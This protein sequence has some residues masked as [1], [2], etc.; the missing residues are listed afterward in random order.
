MKNLSW[1]DS[2]GLPGLEINNP[3]SAPGIAYSSQSTSR[4]TGSRKSILITAGCGFNQPLLPKEKKF[5][6]MIEVSEGKT[7][8]KIPLV[9]ELWETAVANLGI[10]VYLYQFIISPKC[11]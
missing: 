11:A 4:S 1:R 7:Y 8:G 9:N 10:S 2:T 3:V 5:K 6:Y